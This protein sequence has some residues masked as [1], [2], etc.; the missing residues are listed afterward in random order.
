MVP[1]TDA[2]RSLVEATL[3]EWPGFPWPLRCMRPVRRHRRGPHADDIAG[4]CL[5]ALTQCAAKFDPGLGPSLVG[6]AGERI[7]RA[8]LEAL[9]DAAGPPGV[10]ESAEWLPAPEAE[11]AAEVGGV[12]AALAT[13]TPGERAAVE[14]RHGFD[15]GGRT[16]EAF[17]RELGVGRQGLA[18][19]EA[20]AEA[21]LLAALLE[22]RR[23]S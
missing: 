16:E 19:L 6:Y 1:L 4:S 5:L 22:P 3:R 10:P 14:F 2:Q 15:G 18:D 7:F 20:S 23:A 13:L 17:R 11:P 12:R 9:G 21:K 8:A